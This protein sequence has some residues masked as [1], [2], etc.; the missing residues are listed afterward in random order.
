MAKITIENDGKVKVIETDRFVLVAD[1]GT[2]K[3][4]KSIVS[5]MNVGVVFSGT[6]AQKYALYQAVKNVAEDMVKK[7][8]MLLL[9]DM[10]AKKKKITIE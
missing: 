4:D 6:G 1:Q 10:V 7:D 8:P 5:E 2:I 9:I 3:E